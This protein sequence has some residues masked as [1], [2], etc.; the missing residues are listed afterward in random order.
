[1]GYLRSRMYARIGTAGTL[2]F[3]L[4]VEQILRGFAKLTLHCSGVLLLLPAAIFGAV[5]FENQSPAFQSLSLAIQ[6]L[7]RML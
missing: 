1:M 2:D 6:P 7:P 3:N 4:A 5:V